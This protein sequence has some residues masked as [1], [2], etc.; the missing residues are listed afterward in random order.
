MVQTLR[1]VRDYVIPAIGPVEPVSVYRNPVLNACAGGAPESAHKHYSAIDMVPLKPITREALMKTLCGVHSQHG[2]ARRR[3][4]AG[5]LGIERSAVV[6]A[7]VEP[8]FAAQRAHGRQHHIVS[9]HE[10]ARRPSPALH[11]DDRRRG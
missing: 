10:S 8:V 7:D 11:L 5:E 2:E 4:P 6:A 1:F 9:V 3:I